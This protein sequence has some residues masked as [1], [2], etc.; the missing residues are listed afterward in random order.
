MTEKCHSQVQQTC[1]GCLGEVPCSSALCRKPLRKI[2]L[3]ILSKMITFAP[4]SQARIISDE[5]IWMSSPFQFH[6]RFLFVIP[7]KSFPKSINVK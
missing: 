4:I 1:R 7:A 2:E 3:M 6:F 5:N